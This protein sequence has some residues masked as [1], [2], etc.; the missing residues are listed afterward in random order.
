MFASAGLFAVIVI[1]VPPFIGL[2]NALIPVIVGIAAI[3]LMEKKIVNKIVIDKKAIGRNFFSK[4]FT[5]PLKRLFS[6][7]CCIGNTKFFFNC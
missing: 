4:R 6:K 1:V 2:G 5:K 3:T 7:N